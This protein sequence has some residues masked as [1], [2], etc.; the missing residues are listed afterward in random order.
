MTSPSSSTVNAR[1][2]GVLKMDEG[3]LAKGIHVGLKFR[4]LVVF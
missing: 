3:G 1:P 2:G 4:V